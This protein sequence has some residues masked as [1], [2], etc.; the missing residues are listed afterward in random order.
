[1]TAHMYHETSK[2]QALAQQKKWIAARG[3]P[4]SASRRAL[5]GGQVQVMFHFMAESIEYIRTGNLRPLAATHALGGGTGPAHVERLCAGLRD[6]RLGSDAR[7]SRHGPGPFTISPEAN[8]EA[9]ENRNI[10]AYVATG[11]PVDP[12]QR[13][14]AS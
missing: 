13:L 2:P 7:R 14:S 11:R 8:L 5:V 12:F 4:F 1:M 10:D 6:K 9:L 3:M